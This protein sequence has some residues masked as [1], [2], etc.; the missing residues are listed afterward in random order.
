MSLSRRNSHAPKD[1]EE[2]AA[3]KREYGELMNWTDTGI[4]RDLAV[5]HG[6]KDPSREI[7]MRVTNILSQLHSIRPDRQTKR[8]R[9]LLVGWLNQHYEQFKDDIP[10]LIIQDTTGH[11]RGPKLAEWEQLVRDHPEHEAVQDF[12]AMNEGSKI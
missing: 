5:Y 3:R 4:L 11:M 7:L 2:V 8:H 6:I 1:R 9:A 12:R 10:D